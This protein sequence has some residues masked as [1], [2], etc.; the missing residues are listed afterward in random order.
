MHTKVT[1]LFNAFLITLASFLHAQNQGAGLR[2]KV[3]DPDGAPLSYANVVLN[4]A[5]DS[6]LIKVQY[7]EDS[8]QFEITGVEAGNYYLRITYVGL[9][10]HETEAF[11]LA[12]SQNLELGTINMQPANAELKEV[13]VTGKRPL[14][15]LKDDKM[16]FNV[17]KSI[18]AAGNNGLELLRKAP[19]VVIDQNDNI[20]MMGNSGV[21]IFIDGK[22]SPLR[23]EDLA[24]YLRSLQSSDIEAIEIITNPGA[25][26]EAEGNAGII[27]IRLKKDKSLGA[28]AS[29]N[30]GY[31]VGVLPRYNGSINSNYRNKQFNAFLNYSY[32]DGHNV[33]FMNIQR[34][35]S[36][37]GLTQNG[38][39]F[40]NWRGHNF[41]AGMDFY[42][43]DKQTLGFMINGNASDS[44]NRTGNNTRIGSLG[45]SEI[46][47]ILV[48][49]SQ[50]DRNSENFNFNLNYRLEGEKDK[51]LSF[52]ADYG[53]YRRDEHMFQPNQ[54]F[55][56]SKSRM[57]SE[58]INRMI[59]PTDID[60]LTF[61]TDY[62][63]PLL[64]GKF[65]AGIKL[66]Y[67]KT[68]NT[69]DFF[70]VIDGED[71][72]DINRSNNFVYEEIVNAAY[73]N[74]SRQLNKKVNLQAGLRLEQTNSTG[75]LTAMV[76][77]DNERVERNFLD[78][79]PSASINYTPSKT[80]ALQ[81]S[82]S[83]RIN[84]PSYQNLN[85]FR[86]Q[87]DELTFQQGNPFLQ[88][89]YTNRVQLR[90]TFKQRFNT[91]ISYGR[92]TDL[93]TQQTQ[94]GEGKE[95]FITF[96]NVADQNNYSINLAAPYSFTDWWSSYTSIT[97]YYRRNKADF[98][99]GKTIDLTAKAMNLYAQHT[100]QMPGDVAMEVSGWYNSPSIWGGN[101][102]MESQWAM[103]VGLQRK[104]M[105]G[106][107]NLKLSISDVFK[108]S[109]WNGL[110]QFGDLL[111]Q[112]HGGWDSRRLQLNFSYL[113]GNDQLKTNG[114]RKSGLEEEQGRIN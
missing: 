71:I 9:P 57:L 106:R 70:N 46:D 86:E 28:N 99:E 3:L 85:P 31:S 20:T 38:Q 33:N 66:S 78:Y 22:P 6:S 111:L 39:N 53:R 4:R 80:H 103:S 10:P 14:L 90:H 76:D 113:L 83:R 13:V 102:E 110:S 79:F 96:L 17:D 60:I 36:G 91:T 63:Q 5:Q 52:D 82:F 89:E 95:A 109:N 75:D 51:S 107:G 56:P 15:E 77:T 105:Q 11:T 43:N 58:R 81:L 8:G 2:G 64:E 68:D 30:L 97:G 100:F 59:A 40:N 112:I 74:Y 44:D 12:E 61:K 67:V 94:S 42:L 7:T 69:F 55:D 41:K 24:S 49:R 84:R 72:L 16:V 45:S 25:K 88:P 32:N 93:I 26:Y 34:E 1:L 35:Q 101:F 47:S 73:V 108:T 27:N 114:K 65:G 87:L 21:R 48:A 54:Y 29:V 98:G 23:G 18:N 37:V 62:E 50:S 104:V 19:G 92:T